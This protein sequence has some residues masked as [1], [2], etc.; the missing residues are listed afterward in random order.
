MAFTPLVL[1]QEDTNNSTTVTNT[2]Y[3]GTPTVTTG[4]SSI[5]F[6]IQSDV[7]S[8]PL[9]I[10][11]QFSDSDDP[12]TFTLY[13]SDTYFTGT[14]PYPAF[15]KVYPIIKKYYRVYVD[16]NGVTPTSCRINSRLSTQ[17][18]NREETNSVSTFNNT[19]QQ[20]ID[21]FGKLRVSNPQTLLDLRLPYVPGTT[22]SQQFLNNN[23][24][25]TIGTNGGFTGG[26]TGKSYLPLTTINSGE[27]GYI[28]SQSRNYCVYQPGKSLLVLTSAILNADATYGSSSAS[29]YLRR[30]GYYDDNNGFYFEYNGSTIS[31]N[32]RTS[33]STTIT[34]DPTPSVS[35][36]ID[37]MDGTGISGLKLDFATAQLFVIDLEWLG[38]GRLRFGFYA[39]GK[40][41]Y[42]HQITNINGLNLGPYTSGINLPIRYEL[43]S[44]GTPSGTPYLI[45]ICGTVISEGGYN[46]AGRSFSVNTGN[47]STGATAGTTETAILAIRGGSSNYYHQIILPTLVGLISTNAN[48]FYIMRLRLYHDGIS[49]LSNPNPSWTDVDSANS[50]CQYLVLEGGSGSVILNVNQSTVINTNYIITKGINS[51]NDLSNIFNTTILQLTSNVNNVA[52]VLV[53]TCQAVS[54]TVSVYGQLS[55]QEIY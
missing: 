45:Q 36:N 20:A 28:K 30:V 33:N 43:L 37:P 42:C 7:S 14:S 55:W 32:I 8:K 46:P 25:L 51:L 24:S 35:W 10:N 26:A 19:H 49:F 3:I 18:E 4:F 15:T 5:I 38:V 13:Y 2:T 17:V 1:T 21:A 16:F 48:D 11:I 39:Y 12:A 9:G 40:I 54:G 27:I 29:G 34:N 50:I 22:G 52:D 31:V 53:L 47:P 41:N 44:T 6:T 23:Q